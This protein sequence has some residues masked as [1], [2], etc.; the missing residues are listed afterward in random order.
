MDSLAG[1]MALTAIIGVGIQ[2]LIEFLDPFIISPLVKIIESMLGRRSN[3]KES[4]VKRSVM[5]FFT[6]VLGIFVVS[7]TGI[8]LLGLVDVKL[9][10]SLIDILLTALVVGGDTEVVNSAQKFFSSVKNN[11]KNEEK[12]SEASV[13]PPS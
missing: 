3:D 4:S 10:K 8:S 9:K 5:I 6:T 2:Q 12:S 13:N 11:N 7:S 1:V